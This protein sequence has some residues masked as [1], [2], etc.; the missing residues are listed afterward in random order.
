MNRGPLEPKASVL[1]KLIFIN[2][3]QVL[4]N[5]SSSKVKC[6]R[7]ANTVLRHTPGLKLY[8]SSILQLIA[9]ACLVSTTMVDAAFFKK[10]GGQ[11]RPQCR[12]TY[13]TI[14]STQCSTT[15]TQQC[16]TVYETKYETKYEQACSTT[17][18]EVCKQ[19]YRDV[20]DKQCSTI[21]EQ[22]CTNEQQTTYE[23]TYRDEC[24]SVPSQVCSNSLI[25]KLF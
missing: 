9:L 19:T 20:P 16:A 6:K 11:Q 18:E 2:M 23:T 12:V 14:Y 21:Q 3:L 13:E 10:G 15:Y 1:P 25:S 22:E 17:Y 8:F 4:F 5:L 24:Q 7:L